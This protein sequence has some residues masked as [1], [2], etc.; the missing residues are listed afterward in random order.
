M[1]ASGAGGYISPLKWI[2]VAHNIG[3]IENIVHGQS[4]V[5][6]GN[7]KICVNEFYNII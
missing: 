6:K 1:T 3:S 2:D 4:H 5:P 7:V